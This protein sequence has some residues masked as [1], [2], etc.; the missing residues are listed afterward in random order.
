MAKDRTL[1]LKLRALDR[2]SSVI[3]KVSNKFP[4]LTKNVKKAAVANKIFNHQ[5]K[6]IRATLTKVS[7]GLT[8]FGRTL[9]VGVTLPLLAAGGAGVK[10]FGDFEQGLKGIEKTTGLAGP[11]LEKLG[12]TFD[13]L[14]TEIPVSTAEMLELAQA[15]GQLGIKGAANLEKFT[16]TMAKLSRASDVAGEDGA[17]AIARILTV[18]GDGISKVDRFSAALVD[19]GNNA[20]A[21]ESEILEVSNRVAG[22]I[23]RFDV[24]SDRV[25]GISTALKSLGKNAESAGSV[26]GRAFDSIDQAIKGGGK[27]AQLLSKLTGIAGKDLKK[28]FET[29][30]AGV[31]EKFVLGLGK[32]Q[33][34]G[35]NLIKVMG[36]LGLQ[37]VRIND[38]LGTLAKNPEVL[39]ENMDRASKAFQEN[40]ALQK[41]FEV[42]TKTLNSALTIIRNTFTSLLTMIGAE[43]APVVLFLSKVFK[44]LMNI[45]RE[46]PTI[47][48]VAIALGAI[49]AVVGPILILMGGAI[50]AFGALT[51][52]AVALN[53]SLLPLMGIALGITAAL[54]ALVAIGV[55][56]FKKWDSIK[57]FFNENPFGELMKFALMALNPIGALISAIRLLIASFKGLDAVKNVARD[58][59][60]SFIADRIFGKKQTFGPDTGALQGKSP[61]ARPQE[62]RVGGKIDVLF[63][64][65]PQGSRV[66]SG[67]EGPLDFNLGFS[68]GVQ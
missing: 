20:A 54:A 39:S 17:K 15:G 21:S 3:D 33:K 1:G 66:N 37:G 65:L 24:G 58:I 28:N 5:T 43:L 31:F 19:L 34:G 55:V 46:N 26:V 53:I 52:A 41:E 62:S 49:A 64:N 8:S 30:A 61:L 11:E 25:L 6:Q 14:S 2:M 47:R 23:G 38:I 63:N 51:T 9:T 48:A 45:F 50:I 59:L 4:K 10:F 40:T 27:Q 18:T 16:L 67:F 12:R 57:K 60:P 68:G 56:V 35:G 42:Q 7:S 22:A 13:Q 36:A 44:G 32:V 29:D